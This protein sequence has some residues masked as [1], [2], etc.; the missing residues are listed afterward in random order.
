MINA[1][2]QLV[3]TWQVEDV[4]ALAEEQGIPCTKEQAGEILNR[5]DNV[6]DCNYGRTLDTIGYYLNELENEQEEV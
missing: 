5:M 4:T 1:Q 2:G 3:I 6:Y